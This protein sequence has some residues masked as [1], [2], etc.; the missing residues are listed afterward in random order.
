MAP[1][2]EG[3]ERLAGAGEDRL[4]A[5]LDDELAAEADRR[6]AV[7]RPARHHGLPGRV[8]ILDHVHVLLS[9]IP[10]GVSSSAGGLRALD[11][12]DD[13]ADHLLALAPLAV[14]RP[15]LLE[16]PVEGRRRVVPAGGRQG[17]GLALDLPEVVQHREVEFIEPLELRVADL[18]RIEQAARPV[19]AEADRLR[20]A[21]DLPVEAVEAVEGAEL[22]GVDPGAGAGPQE[23]L[24]PSQLRRQVLA[25][26]PVDVAPQLAVLEPSI[27]G[28][29]VAQLLQPVALSPGFFVTVG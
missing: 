12:L 3:V 21:V 7:G 5:L 17:G 19:V 22:A 18:D 29:L 8:L 13:I 23:P 4:L 26:G 20:Q 24:E 2:A 27:T 1:R 15:H 11:T 9:P 16:Q 6:R 28:D 14:E 10:S 25:K